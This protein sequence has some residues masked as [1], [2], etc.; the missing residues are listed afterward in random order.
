M[1]LVVSR[2]ASYR[3]SQ[4][5][6]CCAACVTTI[7]SRNAA[8]RF[9]LSVRFRVG[10]QCMCTCQQTG[11]WF[12][13]CDV[14]ACNDVHAHRTAYNAS[15]CSYCPSFGCGSWYRTTDHQRDTGFRSIRLRFGGK[16]V[17]QRC[18]ALVQNRL[19]AN[20]T[21]DYQ[22]CVTLP[23]ASRVLPLRYSRPNETYR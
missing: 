5:S 14:Q 9:M 4:L 16:R 11:G 8:K 17:L 2:I 3:R 21:G 15:R 1:S 23:C 6:M 18:S 19:D 22:L 7:P 10:S 12:V 13:L 20:A